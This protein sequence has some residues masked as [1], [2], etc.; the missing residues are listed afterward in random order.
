MR[1]EP[2]LPGRI[3]RP[4]GPY[5]W[6]DL[7]PVTQGHL[8]LL[9]S[10]SVL[11]YLFLCA[12]GNS[13]GVSFWGRSRISRVV[14]VPEAAIGEALIRL[15]QAQL[16]AFRDRIV[17]VLP[18]PETPVVPPPPPP[19]PQKRADATGSP[20]MAPGEGAPA[21]SEIE[22]VDPDELSR[23]ENEA[24]R[25]LEKLLG[26]PAGEAMVKGVALGLAREARHQ[27]ARQEKGSQKP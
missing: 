26:R 22:V 8:E 7:R 1:I 11:T 3:R 18:V 14:H 24:R 15:Q 16:I 25:R 12:V 9:D 17:Q 2:L 10:V 4:R 6:V 27:Q 13:D 5:G 21:A 23:H 20:A 19:P